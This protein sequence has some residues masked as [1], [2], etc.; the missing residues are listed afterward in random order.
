MSPTQNTFANKLLR[1]EKKQVPM[2][3]VL[4]VCITVY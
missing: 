4:H 2:P 3:F 1:S